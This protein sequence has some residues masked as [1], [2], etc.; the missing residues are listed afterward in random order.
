M[1]KN[2]FRESVKKMRASLR[3]PERT[4]EREQIFLRLEELEAY[5]KSKNIL[6]FMNFGSEIEMDIFNE[7]MLKDKKRVFLP[8]IEKDGTLSVVEFGTE[9][10]IGSFGIR[11][12]IGDKYEGSLDMI[13]VPGLAFDRFG[14]RI[15]YGKGYYDKLLLKYSEVLKVAPIFSLQLF[16]E[17]PREKHDINIDIIIIKNE[18]LITKKY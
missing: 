11:E 4:D 16:P 8:R 10:S 5:K 15:G 2:I 1:D 14:N 7:K 3:E 6:S 18:I 17:I 9:F 12:P 13:L